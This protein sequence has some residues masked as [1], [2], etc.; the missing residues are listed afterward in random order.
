MKIDDLLSPFQLQ[1]DGPTYFRNQGQTTHYG[2]EAAF[3]YEI[4]S[5][6]LSFRGAFTALSATFDGG[7]FDG[8]ELPG[9]PP[10]RFGATLQFTPGSHH[11]TLDNQWVSEFFADNENSAKNSSYTLLDFRW[12]MDFQS[13]AGTRHIRPFISISNLLDTRYNSSVFVNAF[14]NRFFEPGSS[15]NFRA[16]LQIGI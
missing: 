5:D 8:N 4:L 15:R 2:V 14:G 13:I 7:E 16:G 3:G 10:I 1:D 9:V 12:T 6:L 11:L